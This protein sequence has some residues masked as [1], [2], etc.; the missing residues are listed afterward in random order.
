MGLASGAMSMTRYKVL[1][2]SKPS[3]TDLNQGIAPFKAKPLSLEGNQKPEIAY[4]VL[5][6][7]PDLE[8]EGDYWDMS[9][10]QTEGGYVMRIRIEKRSVPGEL[11]KSL[12]KEH[13][14]AL[15]K[16]LERR[17]S[18]VESRQAK[19]QLKEELLGK[20]L[21]TIRFID[22]F[23]SEQTDEITVFTTSKNSCSVFEH[24]FRK[25]I[26][27]PLGGELVCLVPPLF[28]LDEMD[29][30]GHSQRAES[31]GRLVPATLADLTF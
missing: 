17:P 3:L 29:W 1:G 2:L 9:D 25:S 18:R 31:I 7:L 22:L 19:E 4:W 8:R 6:N 13:L 28:G 14:Q 15:A 24:I 11:L 27:T 30:K 26:L 20:A 5:P 23:W 16:T 10:C 12:H 21:P